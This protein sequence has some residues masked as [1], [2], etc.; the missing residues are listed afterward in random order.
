[1][2]HFKIGSEIEPEM[3]LRKRRKMLQN[4]DEMKGSREFLI[5][6]RSFYVEKKRDVKSLLRKQDGEN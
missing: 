4:K 6:F 1:M 2:A 5:T 3:T